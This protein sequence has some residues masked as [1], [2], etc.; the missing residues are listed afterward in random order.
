M[1]YERNVCSVGE[2]LRSKRWCDW[3]GLEDGV[4]ELGW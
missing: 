3:R 2:L 1:F 4:G